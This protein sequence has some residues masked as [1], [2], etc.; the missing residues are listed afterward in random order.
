M[1]LLILGGTTFL[2]RHLIESALKNGHEVTIFTRGRQTIDLSSEI[3]QLVGDR[4]NNLTALKG[5]TWDRVIDTSGYVPWIVENSAKLLADSVKHYT[6]ISSISVYS[7]L[8]TPGI[9][10]K[11]SV[12][13]MTTKELEEVRT[14]G[15]HETIMNYYGALKYLC[16]EAAK[17]AMPERV[18]NIRPGLIVGQYDPTD[19]FTYWIDRISKGGE[20]L[21]PGRSNKTVQFI[22]AGD[23]ADWIIKAS[24]KE[25][26]GE[27]NAAGPDYSLTMGELLEKCRD[28][29][30][31][32]SSLIWV[33]EDFLLNNNVE[34]WSDMPLWI[35]DRFNIP[36]FLN[37]DIS[38]ALK[39]GLSFK[40]LEEIL[41]DTLNWARSRSNDYALKA[42]ITA[43]RE[44]ELLR[45]WHTR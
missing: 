45:L 16:E 41:L 9:D 40:P 35:P 14:S 20:I 10:E 22:H 37:A 36:G 7:D 15:S 29:S 11:T 32:N 19:R 1:K 18:L 21:C 44:E 39:N 6:F 42:G 23:L 12:S 8:E 33:S 30:C 25:L 3:E 28:I 26:I 5:R 27:F 34:P 4:E 17:Q 43:S 38:K 2:G 13:I 31:S 24:E